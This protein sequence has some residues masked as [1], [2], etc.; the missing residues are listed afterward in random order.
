MSVIERNAALFKGYFPVPESEVE[1]HDIEVL[2]ARNSQA[3]LRFLSDAGRAL[4]VHSAYDPA[5]EAHTLAQGVRL[6]YDSV[7]LVFGIGLMYHV[8]A[9]VARAFDKCRILLI[10]PD[11]RVFDVALREVDFSA[12]VGSGK[13]SLSIAQ[14]SDELQSFL[15]TE[16]T[17]E[18]FVQTEV[19]ALPAYTA[20]YPEEYEAFTR[21]LSAV[22][23]QRRTE[24]LTISNQSQLWVQNIIRNIKHM[25]GSIRHWTFRGLFES[26]PGVVVSAGPSLDKNVEL[27]KKLKGKA[28]IIAAYSSLKTLRAFD[29]VP[30]IVV[31]VDRLQSYVHDV[32]NAVTLDMPLLY[33]SSVDY[34]LLDRATGVKIYA[35]TQDDRFVLDL[36]LRRGYEEGTLFVAGS[37]AIS[38]TDFAATA[39][40]DPIIFVGQDLA[41]TGKRLH[42]AG[43]DDNHMFEEYLDIMLADAF[44]TDDIS[45]GK[46]L[47]NFTMN[48]YRHVLEEYIRFDTGRTGRRYIDATE[49]G[50]VI[51]GTEILTLADV[52]PRAAALPEDIDILLNAHFADDS[53]R[54]FGESEAA[55]FR[56]VI[57][58]IRRD[59]VSDPDVCELAS[60]RAVDDCDIEYLLPLVERVFRFL[61]E[62]TERT[63]L[64]TTADRII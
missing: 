45:G 41:F 19:L 14:T 24:N 21:A 42:S 51:G 43:V 35:P 11:P 46:V 39:G 49:G 4:Y 8:D 29:V 55:E 28:L 1:Y 58:D 54:T 63:N 44:E 61:E 32:N 40:C 57:A 64:H 33:V 25:P 10:E 2:P 31:A 59:I 15:K 34:R 20:R 7:V 47:T 62:R 36:Y 12:A 56:Q 27:L 60:V 22:T 26:K 3:T 52:I 38:A 13:V 9:L 48:M 16:I 23:E 5:S 30:D 18:N 6:L 53:N 50:A 17:S 37:V